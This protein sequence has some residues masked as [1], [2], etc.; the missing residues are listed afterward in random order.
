MLF[1]TVIVVVCMDSNV[2]VLLQRESCP[3]NYVQERFFDWLSV[4]QSEAL[5][6]MGEASPPPVSRQ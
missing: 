3:R 2:E 5:F 1:M 6:V 4:A